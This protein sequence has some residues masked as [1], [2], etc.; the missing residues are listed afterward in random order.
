MFPDELNGFVDM[1][2][3]NC[4]D[5]YNLDL[6]RKGFGPLGDENPRFNQNQRGRNCCCQ[7]PRGPRGPQGPMGCPGPR[8]PRG[9]QGPMGVPGPI[10]IQG[11]AGPQGPIGATGA[12][13][14]TGGN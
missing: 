5:E 12:T 3:W 10:G 8:G 1:N 9:F 4:E 14:A 11:P 2:E 7:G 13:G 6:D